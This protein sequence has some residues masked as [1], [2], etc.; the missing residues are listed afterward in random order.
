[1]TSV[2]YLKGC[3]RVFELWYEMTVSVRFVRSE[4]TVFENVQYTQPPCKK[5]NCICVG[6]KV[7]LGEWVC[8]RLLSNR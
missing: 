4:F 8:G 1:M 3:L 5:K 7:C 2:S 6:W